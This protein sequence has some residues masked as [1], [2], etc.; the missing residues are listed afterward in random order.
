M[1]WD[2]LRCA[3]KVIKRSQ[4]R[5]IFIEMKCACGCKYLVDFSFSSGND[6]DY[7]TATLTCLITIFGND[8][9][10]NHHGLTRNSIKID[11]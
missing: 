9:N 4:K 7:A 8:I 5:K 10:S 6:S 1:I 3:Y 11:N 2:D